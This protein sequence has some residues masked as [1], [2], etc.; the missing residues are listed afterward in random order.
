MRSVSLLGVCALLVCACARSSP[1][2]A[3][4]AGPRATPPLSKSAPVASASAAAAQSAPPSSGAWTDA[5]R[6][7]RWAEA[8]RLIDALPADARG[9]PDVRFARA[10]AA[11]QLG[12]HKLA[13]T[14]LDGLEAKLPLLADEIARHRARSELQAGPFDAAAKWFAAQPGVDAAL[15]AAAAFERAGQA[16]KARSAVERALSLLA[17]AKHDHTAVE[18]RA[19]GLRARLAEAAGN[20]TLAVVD[21]RWIAVH[22]PTS[23][24]AKDVDA[25]IHKLAPKRA[26]TPAERF[27]RAKTLAEAGSIDDVDREVEQLGALKAK[28]IRPGDLLHLRGLARYHARRDY[29]QAATL[30]DKAASAGSSDVARDLFYAARSLSRAQDDALAIKRFDSLARRFPKTSWAETAR[31]LGARL[32]F[33]LGHWKQAASA[34]GGYLSHYKDKG[35]YARTARYE[36]A[37]AWLAGSRHKQAAR[38]FSDLAKATRDDRLTA[39][40]RELEGVALARA[41]DKSGAAAR[42]RSVIADLPLSFPALASASRLAE[43]GQSAPAPIAPPKSAV[44]QAPL[45]VTL[46]PKVALLS[47]IGLDGDAEQALVDFEGEIRRQHGSRGDEAVCQAYGKLASA[48]RRYRV[49]QRA[50]SWSHLDNAPSAATRWVWECIYPRPYEPVVREAEQQWQ[51][52]HDL[53]YAVM[54]QESAFSPDVVSPAKAVGLL[55]LVPATARNVAGELSVDFDPLLLE[56]P[57]Y[58]IRLGSYYLG[59]VLKTFGG[60]VALAAAA[61]NAGPSAVSQWLA[62]GEHLPLDVWVARIP[63]SETRG[64]V[65]RVIGNMA[66]YAYL[67]GG[68]S[69]LPS[70]SLDLPRG[71]RAGPG[72]Y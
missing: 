56:S 22:A 19:H 47:R 41:G 13:V 60:N 18:A 1:A 49:G 5:L 4:E 21:L 46:P 40:Y 58:N 44:A 31:Y 68:A 35:R 2:G 59:K 51:L 12:D 27:D 50:A 36:R 23:P 52:P 30:F 54:R 8:A 34:Y 57:P 9:A 42:F 67:D 53:V 17:H 25:R 15:D 43:L 55:Q 3:G 29:K 38:A 24:E 64:Y 39:R 6:V 26:L 7:E 48:E 71:L 70:L 33:I 69:A 65:C 10:R 14:L 62:S 32:H 63:F 72:Q 28:T 16:E 37:V 45:D 20:A 61:Y 11:A 66:R